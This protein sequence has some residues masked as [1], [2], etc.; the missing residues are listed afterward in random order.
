MNFVKFTEHNDNEGESWNFWLQID[1]NEEQLD[2]LD[3]IVELQNAAGFDN[4]YELEMTPVPGEEVDILVK[5]SNSGY[6]SY[7]NKVT[8][9]LV[10]PEFD[11]SLFEYE[12]EISDAVFDWTGNNFYKGGV[13]GL[14]E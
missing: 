8:G 12:N 3:R 9:T 13:E 14:F 7:E 10:L 11:D 6:M 5:H 2:R 4:E 1:G